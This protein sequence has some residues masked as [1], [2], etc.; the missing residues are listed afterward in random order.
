[1]NKL[2]LVDDEEVFIKS[3]TDG[4]KK[5]EQTFS[6]DYALSVDDA[7]KLVKDTQYNLIISDIRMQGKSGIDLLLALKNMNYKGAFMAMTAYEDPEVSRQLQELGGIRLINKPFDFHWFEDMVLDFFKKRPGVSGY[8]DALELSSI[9]QM[10]NLEK[11]TLV[12]WITIDDVKGYLA[13]EEGDITDAQYRDKR[14]LEA[15]YHLVSQETGYIEVDTKKRSKKKTIAQPFM[16]IFMESVR[17]K[18]ERTRGKKDKSKHKGES[19]MKSQVLTDL[20]A[21]EGVQQATIMDNLG[22]IVVTNIADSEL[23]DF[24]G[25]TIGLIPQLNDSLPISDMQVI[26]FKNHKEPA[27]LIFPK[28][29]QNVG[30]V[31]KNNR[32]VRG[33]IDRIQGLLGD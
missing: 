11:K 16:H 27:L 18:D 32:S 29:K 22:D 24:I 23:N 17:L 8:I 28:D 10:I 12:V 13:F 26:L 33:I 14:G 25:F 9:L 7:L 3:L 4:L 19:T 1:L 15:A 6:A 30:I 31:V 21:I 2:L 20:L 5:H